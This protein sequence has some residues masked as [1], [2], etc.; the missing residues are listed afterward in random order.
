VKKPEKNFAQ[1]GIGDEYS[2]AGEG[3]TGSAFDDMA[4]VGIGPDAI[5]IDQSV[6]SVVKKAT[7][8]FFRKP[9]NEGFWA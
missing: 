3:G 7:H 9:G 5:G 4:A 1:G 8:R 2:Y 6:K